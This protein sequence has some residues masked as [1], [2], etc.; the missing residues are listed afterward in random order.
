MFQGEVPGI[1][2]AAPPLDYMAHRPSPFGL[3]A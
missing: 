2:L 1:I 3:A